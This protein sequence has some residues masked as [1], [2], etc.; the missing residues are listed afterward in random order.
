[1]HFSTRLSTGHFSVP[2]SQCSVLYQQL[3]EACDFR[4]R[5]TFD[6]ILMFQCLL[7]AC[8]FSGRCC[9]TTPTLTLE[10][11]VARAASIAPVCALP[12][13]AQPCCRGAACDFVIWVGVI[14]LPPLHI[15]LHLK[16]QPLAGTRFA[17][18]R[19][20]V[21]VSTSSLDDSC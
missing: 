9:N 3:H 6:V 15:A 12:A 1:M 10:V 2:L 11:R 17:T 20:Q 18:A 14:F 13:Q 19:L 4:S 8:V 7:F 21:A 5:I 16:S